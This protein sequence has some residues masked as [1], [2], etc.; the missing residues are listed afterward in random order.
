MYEIE[1]VEFNKWVKTIENPTPSQKTFINIILNNF[2]EIASRGTSNGARARYIFSKLNELNCINSDS[3]VEAAD[4]KSSKQDIAKELTQLEVNSFRGFNNLVK[5]DLSKQYTLFYGANGSG[6]SSLCQALEFSLLGTIKEAETRRI[7]VNK[8]IKNNVTNKAIQPILTGKLND[9]DEISPITASYEDYRF[10]FI[11]K[12][13]IDAFAHINAQT[14]R[15]K[16]QQLAALFGLTQFNNFVNDFTDNIEHYI[17]IS[18]PIKDSYS[19]QK[20]SYNEKKNSLGN[21]KEELKEVENQ[22]NSLL[23]EITEKNLTTIED[24]ILFLEGTNN[25]GLL[26]QLSIESNKIQKTLFDIQWIDSICSVNQQVTTLLNEINKINHDISKMTVDT[27]FNDLY[28]ILAKIESRNLNYCPACKTPLSQ[29]LVNP[30]SKATEE[31]NKLKTFNSLREQLRQKLN[32]LA[33]KLRHSNQ[34]FTNNQIVIENLKLLFSKYI[35]NEESIVNIIDNFEAIKNVNQNT[36]EFENSK[37]NLVDQITSLN[38]SAKEIN[39]N[40]EYEKKIR[41]YRSLL[42]KMRPLKGSIDTYNSLITTAE[43][44]IIEFEEKKKSIETEI[45]KEEK[46]NAFKTDFI[47]AYNSMINNLSQ[48]IKKLP[49]VLANDLSLKVTEYYNI[50]NA[51]DADYEKVISF[52]LPTDQSSKI[53]VK[54]ADGIEDDALQLLSEG[55]VKLLGLAILLAKANQANQSFLIFDDIVNAIDDEHRDGVAELLIKNKDFEDKQ[56]ILTCH[57]DQFILK[58]ESKIESSQRKE[59]RS[60]Y[61]FIDAY[62][63]NERGIAFK[64][65]NPKEPLEL[66]KQNFIDG[67]FK[68]AASKCRQ[69]TECIMHN[70]WKKLNTKY[71]IA[72]E[73]QLRRPDDKPDLYSVTN[74][75]ISKVKKMQFSDECKLLENLIKLKDDY[76]WFLLNKGTHFENNQFQFEAIDVRNL[77]SLIEQINNTIENI[78]YKQTIIVKE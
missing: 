12:N 44:E 32:E 34:L 36:I 8:F 37:N 56:L 51:D 35:Y 49:S 66:A 50:M 3:I 26:N 17:T 64:Y 22:A 60:L 23:S 42:N 65:D 7:D 52:S 1:K 41:H 30:F 6:K 29:T 27:D 59:K 69:A 58:L 21:Q 24:A 19:K 54:M 31:L 33:I 16:E 14:A 39:E 28:T 72:L 70:F 78:V 73:V 5:F 67:N 40:N 10:S 2:D 76:N 11:E 53:T 62:I 46:Q 13:R 20:E 61:H 71:G 77:I 74:S 57:A 15:D 45:E 75:L 55:H 18:S 9:S 68:E 4:L 38:K 47:T 25:N 43:K 48:Y 63:Q